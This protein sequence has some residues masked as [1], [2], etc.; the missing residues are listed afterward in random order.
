MNWRFLR[1]EK[2]FY[3]IYV[4]YFFLDIIEVDG[5]FEFK[6]YIF[7]KVFGVYF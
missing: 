5:Y 6:G 4:E 2:V 7:Y 1:K 3:V